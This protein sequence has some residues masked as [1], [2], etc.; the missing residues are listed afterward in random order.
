MTNDTQVLINQATEA[1]AKAHAPYSKFR[2]G[3]IAVAADGTTYVGCNVENAA[4]GSSVCAEVNAMTSAVAHGVTEIDSV[5]VVCLDGAP[6]TPCGGCRQVM[7]EF[8]VKRIV[9]LDGTGT[10]VEM[11][12]DDL[13]PNSFGT[14]SIAN[15]MDAQVNSEIEQQSRA[16]GS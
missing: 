11:S 10:I 13:L 3:A 12:L 14:E 7:R 9:M 15:A 8:G 1:A 6:C 2:V 4:F 16:T 5:A